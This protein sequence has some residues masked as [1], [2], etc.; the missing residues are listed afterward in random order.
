VDQS[1]NHL[2]TDLEAFA[3]AV[4]SVPEIEEPPRPTLAV[5]NRRQ[6]EAYWNRLLRYFLDPSE[7]HG[8]ET[9][10]LDGILAVVADHDGDAEFDHQ[11]SDEIVVESEVQSTSG[12]RPDLLAYCPEEWSVCF[13]LKVNASEGTNQTT[14]YLQDEFLPDDVSVPPGDEYHVYI[15]KAT[16]SDSVADNFYDVSWHTVVDVFDDVLLSTRGGATE[17]GAAQLRDF[18][19]AISEE[20]SMEDQ[21]YTERQREQM[22]LYIEHYDEIRTARQAF[23]AVR[24][25]ERDRW[26]TRFRERYAPESLTD[27]WYCD[28]S[29]YGLLFKHGW[30]CDAEGNPVKAVDDARYRLEFQQF[31]RKRETWA[32]GKLRFRVYTSPNGVP[33]AYRNAF[34]N[35]TNEEFYDDLATIRERHDIEHGSGNKT[36]AQKWYSF[37]PKGGPD[38]FYETLAQAFEEFVELAPVLTEVHERAL[39]IAME[40]E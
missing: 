23:E 28:P 39:D 24:K 1:V 7:P 29:K 32:E 34:K 40:A 9:A 17:R 16:R 31:V 26:A 27:E 20:V 38:A 11:S 25:R 19:D 12:N 37:D 5:L 14:Q 30:R 3:T 18:R 2:Q 33:D 8:F 13:E 10:V 15:S 4:R 21:E 6:T 35:L 22:A 36:Q